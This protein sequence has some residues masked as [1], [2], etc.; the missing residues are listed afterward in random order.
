MRSMSIVVTVVV[1]L[2]AADGADAQGSFFNKRY[3]LSPS[4]P[5]GVPD[6][7]FNT[8]EQCRASVS[9]GNYCSENPQWK[10]EVPAKKDRRPSRG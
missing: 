1:T 10:P 7:S 2:L 3:C 9:G 5:G 6:C 8:W 4:I